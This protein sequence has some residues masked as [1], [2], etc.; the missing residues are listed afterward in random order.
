MGYRLN[1]LIE[2]VLIAVS[3]P[4]LIEFGI[5]Y[6]LESCAYVHLIH[7]PNLSNDYLFPAPLGLSCE[8]D[9]VDHSVEEASH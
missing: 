4:L 9:L 2:P 8:I 6:R 1:L 7:F 3:K 5:H